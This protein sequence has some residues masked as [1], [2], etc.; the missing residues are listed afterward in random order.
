M[1]IIYPNRFGT[2]G[3]PNHISYYVLGLGGLD[4]HLGYLDLFVYH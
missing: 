3:P 4:H 1:E 2:P